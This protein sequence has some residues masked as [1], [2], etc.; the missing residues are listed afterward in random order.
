M[1]C[2]KKCHYSMSHPYAALSEKALEPN[3]LTLTCEG[4]I[5]VNWKRS[6]SDIEFGFEDKVCRLHS[7]LAQ[8]LS[9]KVAR[10]RRS[11]ISFDVYT[12][13]DSEL[14]NSEFLKVSF[15]V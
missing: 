7:V 9:P 12:F 14:F 8:L 6:D 10:L 5:S 15:R 11:D 13:K 2:S 3:E 4:M 1:H